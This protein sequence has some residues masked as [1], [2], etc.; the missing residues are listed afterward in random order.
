[1]KSAASRS[2]NSTWISKKY[3]P[4]SFHPFAVNLKKNPNKLCE[5]IP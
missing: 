1:M 5:K 3:E 4:G 2:F